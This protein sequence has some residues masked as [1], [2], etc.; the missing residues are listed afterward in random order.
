VWLWHSLRDADTDGKVSSPRRSHIYSSI[1]TNRLASWKSSILGD[2]DF[3]LRSLESLERVQTFQQFYERYS[4]LRF[5]FSQ[6]RPLAIWPLEKRLSRAFESEGRY[7][8]IKRYLHRSLLWRRRTGQ[9]LGRIDFAAGRRVPSWSW[10]AY[11]GGISYIS[12]LPGTTD[13]K[14]IECTFGNADSDHQPGSDRESAKLVAEAWNFDPRALLADMDNHLTVMWDQGEHDKR[15][16]LKC[17][18][19]GTSKSKSDGAGP[20][21]ANYLLIVCPT[22]DGLAFE[23]VGVGYIDGHKFATEPKQFIS[24]L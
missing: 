3:P 21:P 6:D 10:Q 23:R 1:L 15:K 7:G 20:P 2:P 8:V 9:S 11:I 22:A 14:P 16:D 19:I 12:V 13:W 24:V 5:T 18:A 17:I 4:L